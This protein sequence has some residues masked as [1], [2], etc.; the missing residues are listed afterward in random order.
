[1]ALTP[2][3]LAS[4]QRP[5]S[6]SEADDRR[7]RELYKRLYPLI[8]Q[9]FA[10]RGDLKASLAVV[11]QELTLL[12]TGIVAHVHASIGSPG[13]WP[14]AH[15]AQVPLPSGFGEALVRT[16]LG[17]IFQVRTDYDDEGA[18]RPFSAV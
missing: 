1:M 13:I 4:L 10:H 12:G 2:T 6:P 17:E 8:L 5:S 9:D 7:M 18:E 11:E 3:Q 16:A 15:A 14:G